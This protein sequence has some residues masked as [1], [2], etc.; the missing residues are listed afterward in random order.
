MGRRLMLA[1]SHGSIPADGL[2]F[3]AGLHD[4]RSMTDA[5]LSG[6]VTFADVDGIAC[7]V[8]DASRLITLQSN[9]RL[10]AGATLTAALWAKN[11]NSADNEPYVML[12]IS[13]SEGRISDEFTIAVRGNLGR[14]NSIAIGNNG[15]DIYAPDESLPVN[16]WHHI[17]VAMNDGQYRIYRDG[18]LIAWGNSTMFDVA[19]TGVGIGGCR[20]SDP[21]NWTGCI[22]GVAIYDRVLNDREIVVLKNASRNK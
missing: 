11:Y 17:A 12:S 10:A 22:C 16:E 1:Q 14:V 7:A 9:D 2:I 15:Q 8:F 18:T 20:H 5:G 21:S 4:Q 13:D 3:Y 19:C 6:N